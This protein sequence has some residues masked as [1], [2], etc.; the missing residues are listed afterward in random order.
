M[1]IF[2]SEM[3]I[4]FPQGNQY[5]GY[6]FCSLLLSYLLLLLLLLGIIDL[7]LLIGAPVKLQTW[8]EFIFSKK[9]SRSFIVVQL[10]VHIPLV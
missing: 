10:S 9:C 1:W 8:T 4:P 7:S 5:T 2:K 3:P 6:S